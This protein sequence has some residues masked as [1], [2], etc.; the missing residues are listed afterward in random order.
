MKVEEVICSDK[1]GT[2]TQ[3]HMTLTKAYADGCAD[4]ENICSSNTEQIRKLLMLPELLKAV[5]QWR[6]WYWRFRK[7]FMRLI[8]VRSILCLR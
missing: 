5:R 3:N 1:T 2:L 4:I 6:L 8:C 7:A